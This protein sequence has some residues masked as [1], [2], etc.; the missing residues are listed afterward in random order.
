MGRFAIEQGHEARWLLGSVE[1]LGQMAQAGLVNVRQRRVMRKFA[2]RVSPDRRSVLFKTSDQWLSTRAPDFIQ[3]LEWT[4]T[5]PA[6]PLED[7]V[8]VSWQRDET[9]LDTVLGEELADDEQP[10][11]WEMP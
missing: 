10:L 3:S 6:P 9:W 5:R 1:R 8:E 7:D 2:L 11:M 4:P